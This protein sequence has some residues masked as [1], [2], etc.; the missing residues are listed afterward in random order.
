MPE[1]GGA[2]KQPVRVVVGSEQDDFENKSAGLLAAKREEIEQKGLREYYDLRK[3]WSNWIIG[4]ICFLILFH[5]GLTIAV[6]LKSLDF[7][8][9]EW[10]VTAVT[11][12]TFLQVVGMGLIAVKF[13][14]SN[15]PK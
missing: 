4:W 10:F 7:V 12:E 6:G 8:N 9:F 2:N 13:L 5:A 15:G 11:V 3:I 1:D 14:F